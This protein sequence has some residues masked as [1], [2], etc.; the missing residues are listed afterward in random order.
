T[1]HIPFALPEGESCFAK[2]VRRHLDIDLISHADADKILAHFPGDVGQD[3]MPV[4]QRDTKHCPRQHLCDRAYQFNWVFLCHL[5]SVS[6][7]DAM[8]DAPM[9]FF[10][11]FYGLLITPNI[12]GGNWIDKQYSVSGVDRAHLDTPTR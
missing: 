10:L 11:A 1:S 6:L 9:Q 4:G 7:L 12:A 2:I 5:C 3:F 8:P